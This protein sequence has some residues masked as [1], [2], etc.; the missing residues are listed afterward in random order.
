ML[1]D[2]DGK[3][4]AGL[5]HVPQRV[6]NSGRL[7]NE[8]CRAGPLQEGRFA[9]AHQV[10]QVHHPDHPIEVPTVGHRGS[11]V[12]AGHQHLERVGCAGG[13]GQHENLTSRPQH[14]RQGP[15]GYLE[16]PGEDGALVR[17][18]CPAGTDQIPQLLLAHL[19]ALAL[20]VASHQAHRQV[21]RV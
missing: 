8:H 6:E 13:G 21:R 9:S 1:V 20:R 16:G 15:L 19:L 5:L 7:G 17:T 18:E 10:P 11:R 14:L 12:P 2:D 3:L 4:L